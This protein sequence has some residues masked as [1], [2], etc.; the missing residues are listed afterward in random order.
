MSLLAYIALVYAFLADI[1]LFDHKFNALEM[2]GATIITAF[3]LL[4]IIL[5]ATGKLGYDTKE[6]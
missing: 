4:T 3:N 5:K 6:E 2:A 1:F